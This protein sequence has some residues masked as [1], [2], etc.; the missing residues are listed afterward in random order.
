MNYWKEEEE[1]SDYEYTPYSQNMNDKKSYIT[2]DDWGTPI[3][4]VTP[5]RVNYKS[6]KIISSTDFIASKIG[7]QRIIVEN[8]VQEAIDHNETMSEEEVFTSICNTKD[9]YKLYL[10]SFITGKL[11]PV[12]GMLDTGCSPYVVLGYKCAKKAGII[13]FNAGMFEEE[14]KYNTI[15]GLSAVLILR[16]ADK[17]I[18]LTVVGNKYTH[19]DID[20]ET[21]SY[22]K[23]EHVLSGYAGIFQNKGID[24]L[25]GF[26]LMK[27]LSK[28]GVNISVTGENPIL[29]KYI[30]F[31]STNNNSIIYELINSDG[32][33][34]KIK[35]AIDS[36]LFISEC[37]SF[38]STFI[39]KNSAFFN[40][41][42]VRIR[43]KYRNIDKELSVNWKSNDRI[44]Q[45]I[46]YDCVFGTSMMKRLAEVRVYPHV[47]V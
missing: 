17:D 36:G 41:E 9:E 33:R 25:I 43:I 34:K 29:Q 18:I 6:N 1:E 39:I 2:V 11:I 26:D 5:K 19:K 7:S 20:P 28:Y 44:G 22:F 47:L 14:P 24:V 3:R 15:I 27:T 32:K 38:N 4:P 30:P 21:K 10:V 40:E 23:D 31:F 8:L 12:Y 37:A 16:V 45:D 35:C 13:Q 46:K 42:D